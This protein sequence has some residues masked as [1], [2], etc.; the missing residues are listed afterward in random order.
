MLRLTVQFLAEKNSF[1]FHSKITE[2]RGLEMNFETSL[3]KR[4]Q[5]DFLVLLE[6]FHS[7]LKYQFTVIEIF[8]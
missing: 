2:W 7:F 4:F 6:Q 5:D 1:F 8:H 3:Q